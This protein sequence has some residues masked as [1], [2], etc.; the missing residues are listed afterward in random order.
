M[1]EQEKKIKEIIFPYLKSMSYHLYKTKPKELTMFMID[2]LQKEC[3]YTS[4][5]LTIEEKKEL[6]RLRVEVKRY[7]EMEAHQVE[8]E[9]KEEESE[10]N[11]D[12]V[13]SEEEKDV[14]NE[15][16]NSK[17]SGSMKP[18]KKVSHR[19]SVSAEVYGLHNSKEDFK[20]RVIQK[21]EEQIS[22]I[23]AIILRSFMFSSL[24][25]NDLEIVINAMEEKKFTANQIVINQGEDGNCLYVVETG[26]LDCYKLFMNN[27]QSQSQMNSNSRSVS[28]DPS[29]LSFKASTTSEG[30]FLKT[31]TSGE[32]FGE[33]ALLY[34]APRAATVKAKTD[35]VLWALDRETFNHIVKEAAQK[36]RERYEMFLKQVDILSTIEPYELMTIC[37]AMKTGVYHKDGFIIKEKEMGDVFYILEEGE[38]KAMKTLEPG[39]AME[40]IKDYHKGDYFGER[41]LISGDPRYAN[42]VATSDVVKVI[43]LDRNSFKRLLGPIE[44]ILKRNMEKYKVYCQ[45]EEEKPKEEQKIVLVEDIIQDET[46]E[47]KK[48]EIKE[49]EVKVAEVKEENKVEE[50]SKEEEIDME[51]YRAYYPKEE[52]KNGSLPLFTEKILSELPQESQPIPTGIPP[53]PAPVKKITPTSSPK[54]S[55]IPPCPAVV[56]PVL[57]SKETTSSSIP[58]PPEVILPVLSSKPK[59]EPVSTGIPKAPLML[60]S[61]KIVPSS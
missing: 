45:V 2:F 19:T 6:E 20:P 61:M 50:E 53:V 29:A 17:S 54:N 57:T 26:E 55:P 40:E 16:V 49:E 3:G 39:K 46:K 43:S 35:V 31:Y 22:R 27:S 10:E 23:K 44:D 52:M 15:I 36:K 32:A 58:K 47:E 14:V 34:N 12:D 60:P 30:K 37:D 8:K 18:I 42:I 59:E 51:K 5:G 13:L 11:S 24:D 21:T 48:E 4:S 1:D 25:K 33:L 7:R 9:N 28:K 56:I 38:C 41:A